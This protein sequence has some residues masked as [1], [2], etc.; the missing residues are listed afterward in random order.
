MPLNKHNKS[1]ID[2]AT[3]LVLA[4][5]HS[6]PKEVAIAALLALDKVQPLE[7]GATNYS[8]LPDALQAETLKQIKSAVE[9][10]HR[11][12]E[13]PQ[14]EGRIRPDGKDHGP[15]CNYGI[16]NPSSEFF[17]LEQPL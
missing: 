12:M 3:K 6:V 15:E 1:V 8:P 11:I 9:H 10:L 16:F 4:E 17:K 5:F 13:N 7:K 14:P 2:I